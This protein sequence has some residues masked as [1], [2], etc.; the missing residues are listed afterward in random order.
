VSL[1][2]V[3]DHDDRVL[4]IITADPDAIASAVALKRL[5]WRRVAH[6]D[7]VSTNEVRR[8]DNLKL[9]KAL[10]LRLPLLEE[11]DISH[12][13]KLVTVDSQPHHHNQTEGL[14]F[15]LVVDHHP[16]PSIPNEVPPEF[17]DIRPD[18]GATA[19][20][21]TCYLR[22]ARIRPN[23]IL[24]TALFYAI[25]TDT[26]NFVRQGKL[27]DMQAFRWLYP[28]IHQPLLSDIESAPISHKSFDVIKKALT[29][30]HLRKQ[31][32]NTFVEHLDHPDT[33]VILADFIMQIDGVN[34]AIVAGVYEERLIVILRS[35]G[36]RSNVGRLAGEA[37]G[38]YGSA[39]GHKH[40]ARAEMPLVGLPHKYSLKHKNLERFISKRLS[41]A[42]CQKRLSRAGVIKAT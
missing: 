3:F 19:T 33:L 40:M 32:A 9:L 16:L 14:H 8:L 37:F 36:L 1:Y 12:Y 10:D 21:L 26:Q 4:V 25:K 35:A 27:E 22:A 29:V 6:I 20:I 24:A 30:T 23:K 2:K 17:C 5:L 15:S 42:L 18:W 28:L 39:G 38:K 34:R 11:T 31:Y 13:S 7:I 41:E